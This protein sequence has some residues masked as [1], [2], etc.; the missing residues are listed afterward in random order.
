MAG[1]GRDVGPVILIIFSLIAAREV[2]PYA[3]VHN[4]HLLIDGYVLEEV[5]TDLGVDRPACTGRP[6]RHYSSATA[7]REHCLQFSTTVPT[8][9]FRM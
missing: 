7:M 2:W 3:D 8:H 4:P 9:S 5:M 6:I 1:I